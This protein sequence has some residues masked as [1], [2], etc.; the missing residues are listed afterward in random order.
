M[1]KNMPAFRHSRETIKDPELSAG[2]PPMEQIPHATWKEK[3]NLLKG[4]WV[5]EQKWKARGTMA[6]ISGL[7]LADVACGAAIGLSMQS[8]LNGLV[9]AKDL[10]LVMTNL[11]LAGGAA[12]LQSTLI[13]Q[14]NYKTLS[15]TI[16]WREWI[17]NKFQREWLSDKSYNKMARQKG[18]DYHP[19]QRIGQDASDIAD[20]ALS[21]GVC[22]LKSVVSVVTFSALLMT[23]SPLFA[24]VALGIAVGSSLITNKIGK[25]LQ[26]KNSK[27][28]Q[29][30]AT[31]RS[32][33]MDVAENSDHIALTGTELVE[34]KVLDHAAQ[35]VYSAKLDQLKLER[36][37]GIF[38]E[39]NTRVSDIIPVA[40]AV[41]F[42]IAGGASVGSVLL[43]RQ[44]YK[45]L[46]SGAGWVMQGYPLWARFNA[47]ADRLVHFS[48]GIEETKRT[49]KTII[50][51]PVLEQGL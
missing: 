35:E 43:A 13:Q 8:A 5:S 47:S 27:V 38:T 10:M 4:Y 36:N 22:L 51:A 41:P 6:L 28:V 15:L 25:P 32:A 18:K 45:E 46:A 12:F 20:Q 34:T 2:S 29:S 44:Y 50:T 48:K 14:K 16:K 39:F 11:G 19:D 1:K 7:I 33:L 30:E 31:L 37:L 9:S 26:K 49:S 42:V 24:A 21:F 17:T 40:L 23:I 3:L